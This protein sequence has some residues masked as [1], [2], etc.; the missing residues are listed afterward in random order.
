MQKSFNYIFINSIL[1][2][3]SAFIL[4]TVIH[5][6]GHFVVYCLAG[7]H[8]ILYH[9]FVEISDPDLS[10]QLKIIA[11]LAGPL[12]S[13]IQGIFFAVIVIRKQAN[14]AV[15]MLFLW[16]SLLGFINFFGYLMLTPLSTTG[17]TGKVAELLQLPYIYRLMTAVAGI[18]VL[19]LIIIR[20]GR[21]FSNFIPSGSDLSGK[22]KYVNALVLFPILA[23]SA[24]NV[25]LALPIPVLLSV[26]YPAT[27]SYVILSAYGA[28]LEGENRFT[29]PAQVEKEISVFIL[30]LTTLL[31]LFNRLLTMGVAFSS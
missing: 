11:A 18:A 16:L 1:A 9:N 28:I 27:S 13:L 19:I 30:I 17:D 26:I 15:Y 14:K 22:R 31:I 4:T 10:V 20:I 5:E 24:V 3:V 6:C 12:T 21:C 25:M 23:G 8:P 29:E 2:F 7:T